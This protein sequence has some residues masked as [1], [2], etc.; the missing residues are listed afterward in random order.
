[1]E[2][3][4]ATWSPSPPSPQA[5]LLALHDRGRNRPETT[6][7]ELA[8]RCAY[9]FFRAQGLSRESPGTARSP[10]RGAPSTNG[11]CASA[12]RARSRRR[13]SPEYRA[14]ERQAVAAGDGELDASVT[15]LAVPSRARPGWLPGFTSN[16][17]ASPFV[18]AP[19]SE[20]VE[21]VS[22]CNTRVVWSAQCA[23]SH[24][25]PHRGGPGVPS[26]RRGAGRRRAARVPH[27]GGRGAVA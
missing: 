14:P 8:V 22:F 15:V 17:G 7:G 4:C 2:T 13:L 9:G 12:R 25:P 21:D 18:K 3:P 23:R 19:R 20:A 5:H 11:A 26:C 10:S 24:R 16:R 1:M 27:L 6:L